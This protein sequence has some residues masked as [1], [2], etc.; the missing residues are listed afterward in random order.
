M[1]HTDLRP[2]HIHLE[3]GGNDTTHDNVLGLPFPLGLGGI[4]LLRIVLD[5]M[6][7]LKDTRLAV[8]VGRGVTLQFERA[9]CRLDHMSCLIGAPAFFAIN[10]EEDVTK[11]NTGGLGGRSGKDVTNTCTI[12]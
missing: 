2:V 1:Q 11:A 8:I 4:P 7:T 9:G 12:A 6:L 10:L 5:H 3:R